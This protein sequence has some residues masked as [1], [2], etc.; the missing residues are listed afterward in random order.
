M[1]P[2][3]FCPFHLFAEE[4]PLRMHV[5]LVSYPSTIWSPYI[6]FNTN[7]MKRNKLPFQSHRA[8]VSSIK[9]QFC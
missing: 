4:A 7:A 8:A 2:Q 6:L 3:H 1:D 9:R 5:F